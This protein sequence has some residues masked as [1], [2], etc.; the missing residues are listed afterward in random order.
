MYDVNGSSWVAG[1]VRGL[2]VSN[3]SANTNSF[4]MVEMDRATEQWQENPISEANLSIIAWILVSQ[5]TEDKSMTGHT[6]SADSQK[7]LTL[8]GTKQSISKV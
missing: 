1:G 2:F 8:V 5:A 6:V 3:S 4:T 7:C